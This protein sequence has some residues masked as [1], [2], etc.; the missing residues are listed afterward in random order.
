MT[1]RIC[2]ALMVILDSVAW[3]QGPEYLH[4]TRVRFLDRTGFERPVESF[5]VLLPK[6]WKA[7]GGVRWGNVGGCRG[8]FIQSTFKASSPDAG[9]QFEMLPVRSFNWTDDRML[10]QTMM[11]GAQG[12][13]CQ[14]NQP[15]SAEQFVDGFARKDLRARASNIRVDEAQRP[16]LQVL[17]Q[18][19]NEVA[20]Q[21][22]QGDSMQTVPAS[23]DITFADGT[24]GILS[25]VVINTSMRRPNYV[26]GGAATMT[27]TMAISWLMR[28]PAGR[29][30]EGARMM[31]MISM[32]HR[33]NPVWKANK[34]RFMNELG[35]TEHRGRM[36]TIRLM[37]EQ[38]RE[39]G[40][41]QSAASDQRMRDWENRSASQDRQHKSFVQ[42]IREVETW[43]DGS[44]GVE[45]SAGYSQGWSRGDGSYILSNKPGFDPSSV[46]QDP[47]WKPM[48]RE[49]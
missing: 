13:G 28:F 33:V 48:Q 12:G 32:S 29:R 42:A 30:Q 25:V 45:L 24:E 8:E 38:A 49:R 34:E 11:A 47:Q 35:N 1:G 7:D 22:G 27:T 26:G 44:G 2:L 18:Q 23:G 43:R 20:R 4:V 19:F 39:Y 41:A 40:R 37:G 17:D 15:F 14:V 3:A 31:H 21:S 10:L 6:G 16:K 9:M 36:E 5:S 46:L